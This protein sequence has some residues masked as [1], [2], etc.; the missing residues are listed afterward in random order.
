MKRF[1]AGG[2]VAIVLLTCGLLFWQ[3]RANQQNPI[4]APP[5]P[6]ALAEGLPEADEDAPEFGAAPPLPP[7]AAKAS[8]EEMRFNRYD[9]NRDNL[10]TRLE[11]MSSRTKA[12]QKLD[13]D[14]NNLLTFEEWATATGERFGKADGNRD[15]QLNRTEFSSTRPKKAAK[16]G[17]RC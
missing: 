4:P 6:A 16:P 17:C 7:S 3:S 11:M 2:G 14:H 10:I 15:G 8:R 13:K 9:R 1:L 5:P 12:F